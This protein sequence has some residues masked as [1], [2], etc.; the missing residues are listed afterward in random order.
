MPAYTHMFREVRPIGKLEKEKEKKRQNFGL[1]SEITYNILSAISI[2]ILSTFFEF[3][4]RA[5]P[6]EYKKWHESVNPGLRVFDP[7]HNFLS[8]FT[9]DCR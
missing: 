3:D 9:F 7:D 6:L 1:G 4:I 2:L 8:H 5:R